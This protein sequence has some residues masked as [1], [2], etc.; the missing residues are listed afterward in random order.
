MKKWASTVI[1]LL[2][3]SVTASP[4]A[5]SS[6]IFSGV[7]NDGYLHDIQG[8]Y[9]AFALASSA[10]SP[11]QYIY[12]NLNGTGIASSINNLRQVLT[13]QDTLVW[14]YSGHSGIK[15]DG[16]DGD[17]S[18]PG[19]FAHD[20]YDETVGMRHGHDQLSDDDLAES[21]L[22]IKPGV[23]QIIV[24]MDVCYAGGFIGG[25]LDLNR[26][27]GITFLGS[28]R[29]YEQSF[30]YSDQPYS[31]FTQG[32]ID[33]LMG[34]EADANQDGIVMASEWFDFAAAYTV[35]SIRGQHPVF[36]GEDVIIARE[37]PLP[38]ASWLLFS[39]VVLLTLIKHCGIIHRRKNHQARLPQAGCS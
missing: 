17:E 8:L 5:H 15:V 37:V 18:A 12:E 30:S 4:P 7:G 28:S 20:R 38:D 23:N 19:S 24:V 2:L 26:V 11:P 34:L 22:N 16:T 29:E 25:N 35:N 31:I 3:F 14:V 13:P 32:L 21:F 6:L 39:G 10:S 36:Y 9:S 33:G 1:F 27:T